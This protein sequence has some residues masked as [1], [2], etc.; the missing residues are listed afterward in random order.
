MKWR[1]STWRTGDFLP[2]ELEIIYQEIRRLSCL[3]YWILCTR[4]IG[5]YRTCRIKNDLTW[6]IGDYLSWRI[7]N[8]VP[9]DYEPGSYGNIF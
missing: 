8:Y 2:G 3:E 6:K 5:D 9:K 1:F 4:I 7:E